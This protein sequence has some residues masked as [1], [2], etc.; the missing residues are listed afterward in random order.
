M[1]NPTDNNPNQTNHKLGQH[2]RSLTKSNVVPLSKAVEA[3]VRSDNGRFLSETGEVRVID[4][5]LVSD[6]ESIP[7]INFS[8]RGLTLRCAS[9]LVQIGV[10][11]SQ[12]ECAEIIAFNNDDID[13]MD[14]FLKKADR[15]TLTKYLFEVIFILSEPR[16]LHTTKYKTTNLL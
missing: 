15:K 2:C 6:E 16:K 7:A 10:R 14:Q 1:N 12:E 4:W 13:A 8:I 3:I 9:T 11:A 5:A